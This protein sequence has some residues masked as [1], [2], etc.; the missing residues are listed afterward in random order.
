MSQEINPKL[1]LKLERIL[2]VPLE[3]VWRAWTTP[4]HLKQWFVPN[5]WIITDCAIDLRLGG[6]F[7]TIMRSPEG[8]EFPNE[9]CYLEIT[10]NKKLTWTSALLPG[11]RPVIKATNG[12]ELLFT[13]SI[14]LESKGNQTKQIAIII[15]GDEESKTNHENMGFHEGWGIC[16][17][18]LVEFT[19]K[20]ND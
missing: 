17:D 10:E 19:K 18:Q 2:D 12:P 11:F 14:L 5:P 7:K 1:D 13:T 20:H 16:F 4:E 15:H 8:Q 3:K 9:G 6:S